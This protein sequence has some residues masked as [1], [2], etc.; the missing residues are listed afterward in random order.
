MKNALKTIAIIIA[1]IFIIGIVGS[2]V[3]GALDSLQK[4]LDSIPW[5]LWLIGVI[6]FF[7]ILSK[8]K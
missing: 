7:Y 4:F 3:T 8:Q 6:G 2:V 1:G 5:W